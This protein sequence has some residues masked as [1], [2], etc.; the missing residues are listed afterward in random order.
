MTPVTDN[1]LK[2]PFSNYSS[3]K[4][5]Y[6]N[7]TSFY[8]VFSRC[9]P[10]WPTLG[11]MSSNATRCH[12]T[13]E[14]QRNI[15]ANPQASTDSSH[16]T[17]QKSK[18]IGLPIDSSEQKQ[19]SS[20][21]DKSNLISKSNESNEIDQRS[22]II[23]DFQSVNTLQ[24]KDLIKT[25][26]DPKAITDSPHS[27]DQ[28]SEDNDLINVSLKKEKQSSSVDKSNLIS[29]SNESNEIDQRSVTIRDF[30]PVNTWQTQTS[31]KKWR[32]SNAPMYVIDQSTGKKYWNESKHIL[33]LKCLALALGTPIVHLIGTMVTVAYKIARLVTFSHFW[34]KKEGEKSYSF[35][36]RAKDAGKDLLRVAASPIIIASLE[37]AAIYGMVKPYDGRKLF[38]S[39]ERAMYGGSLL[40]PC[41]QPQAEEHLFGGDI[42]KQNSW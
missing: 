34:E 42:N 32:K 15:T 23:I 3:K 40:A 6:P 4:A 36:E 16:S 13:E 19:Q 26:E 38:A 14:E 31:G 41:F 21:V 22:V 2:N 9:I 35:K 28:N 5:D 11:C 29:K 25:T 33:R 12:S 39:I 8:E 1:P 24:A 27:T 17:D 18:N 7:Q 20:S 37:L 30:Q 10:R